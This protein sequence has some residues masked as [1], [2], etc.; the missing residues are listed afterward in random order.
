M[1]TAIAI[2]AELTQEYSQGGFNGRS[3]FNNKYVASRKCWAVRYTDSTGYR[4]T[5]CFKRKIDAVAVYEWMV[6]FDWDGRGDYQGLFI[7]WARANKN[8]IANTFKG[9]L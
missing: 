6:S 8:P 4:A 1:Q 2:N 9:E 7:D 3:G 5:I